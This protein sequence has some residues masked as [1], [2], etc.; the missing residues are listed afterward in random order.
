MVD[1][2]QARELSFGDERSLKDKLAIGILNPENLKR[3]NISS[4]SNIQISSDFGNIVVKVKE[5]KDLP[6]NVI[7]M[8]VSIWAN[9]ITGVSE[10]RLYNK[11][12]R[13]D[14]VATNDPVKDI[15]DLID[16]LKGK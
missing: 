16:N 9:Q 8:P 12:L 7:I 2:D 10:N 11:N 1:Y 5:D 3:L 14:A 13:V 15:K 6:L 4:N